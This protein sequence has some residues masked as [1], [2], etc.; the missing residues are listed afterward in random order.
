MLQ[1]IFEEVSTLK[2]DCGIKVFHYNDLSNRNIVARCNKTKL[3]YEKIGKKH[4]WVENNKKPCNFYYEKSY[5]ESLIPEEMPKKEYKNPIDE[6]FK[7]LSLQDRNQ[8]IHFMENKDISPEAKVQGIKKLKD[9]DNQLLHKLNQLLLALVTRPSLS[10]KNNIIYIITQY[11]N[12]NPKFI[13]LPNDR[14]Y[15]YVK[16]VYDKLEKDGFPY[17]EPKYTIKTMDTQPKIIKKKV[18]KK[19]QQKKDLIGEITIITSEDKENI[20]KDYFTDSESE[21]EISDDLSESSDS[22]ESEEE[23]EYL[24]SES[25]DELQGDQDIVESDKESIPEF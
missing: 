1:Q 3:S 22:Q 10:I 15:L 17:K 20:I 4:N 6:E 21:E 7:L 14:F 8:Y 13:K 25:E 18:Q 19:P 23:V 16:K 9:Y 12:E 5:G 2:C 11:T 24:V